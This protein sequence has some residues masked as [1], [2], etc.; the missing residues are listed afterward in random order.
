MGYSRIDPILEFWALRNCIELLHKSSGLDWRFFYYH[1][2]NGDCFQISILPEYNEEI[3]VE[4]FLIESSNGDEFE[5]RIVTTVELLVN[6]LDEI[7]KKLG[8]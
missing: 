4:L 7:L 2:R 6:V 5:E 3:I 1:N 8:N